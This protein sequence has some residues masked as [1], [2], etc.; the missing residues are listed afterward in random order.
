VF[1]PSDQDDREEKSP[2]ELEAIL[3]PSALIRIKPIAT[4]A[5]QFNSWLANNEPATS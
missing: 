4:G 1:F 3:V 2:F 5:V